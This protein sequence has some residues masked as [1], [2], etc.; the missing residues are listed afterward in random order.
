VQWV[1]RQSYTHA[2]RIPEAQAILTGDRAHRCQRLTRLFAR[3][4]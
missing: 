4:P 1:N 2:A 3:N